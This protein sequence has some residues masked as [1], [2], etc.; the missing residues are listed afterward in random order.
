MFAACLRL[1]ALDK[2]ALLWHS[3]TRQQHE[4]IALIKDA[5]MHKIAISPAAL[6]RMTARMGKLHPYDAMAPR[7]W[8]GSAMARATREKAGRHCMSAS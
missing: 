4:P 5:A 3:V 7:T 6:D 8:F 1:A 2:D